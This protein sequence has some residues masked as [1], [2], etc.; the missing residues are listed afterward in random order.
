MTCQCWLTEYNK[1]TTLEMLMVEKTVVI[2]GR[3]GIRE[4]LSVFSIQFYYE[5]KIDQ[6]NSL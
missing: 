1:C 6:K 4:L 5:P 3:N 2:V